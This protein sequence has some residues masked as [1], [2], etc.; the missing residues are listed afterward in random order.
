MHNLLFLNIVLV[1]VKEEKL[2]KRNDV[3]VEGCCQKHVTS[4]IDGKMHIN[5]AMLG[6]RIIL[7]IY[8]ITRSQLVQT[9]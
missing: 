4:R 2:K 8:T 5:M 7:K 9:N 1:F 6:T 3:G